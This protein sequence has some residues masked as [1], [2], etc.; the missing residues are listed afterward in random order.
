MKLDNI[1]RIDHLGLAVRSI[2]E[3]LRFWRDALGLPTGGAPEEVASEKVR[4][5]F[6][7]LGES[8]IELLEPLGSDSPI[9]R[10]LERRGEGLHHVCL[11]V[12]SLE[13]ALETLEGQ[14][15]RPI[16][17]RIRT[18]AGGHRIAFIHPRDT[19]G[20]LVELAEAAGA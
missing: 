12:E 3:S 7:P 14:S 6:L 10:H 20:V 17:P 4:V 18:G 2:D 11:R 15:I 9:A 1:G 5:V 19:G 13:A 16:E 8:R